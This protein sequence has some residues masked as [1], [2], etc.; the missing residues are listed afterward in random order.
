MDPIYKET[1]YGIEQ[2]EVHGQ[3]KAPYVF[4]RGDRQVTIWAVSRAIAKWIYRDL[5]AAGRF[6]GR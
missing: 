6:F 3:T 4:G 5:V 2:L 1:S